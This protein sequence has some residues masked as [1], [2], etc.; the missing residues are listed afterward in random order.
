MAS[1]AYNLLNQRGQWPAGRGSV[2]L[3]TGDL[4]AFPE[5]YF[6]KQDVLVANNLLFP[7]AVNHRIAQDFASFSPPGA[8]LFTTRELG[9]GGGGG[10]DLEAE[11]TPSPCGPNNQHNENLALLEKTQ[12]QRR[13]G[14]EKARAGGLSTREGSASKSAS[15]GFLA[16]DYSGGNSRDSSSGTTKETAGLCLKEEPLT[17][18]VTWRA[19]GDQFFRYTKGLG[20]DAGAAA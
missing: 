3:D 19:S 5:R 4:T 13:A 1:Q 7:E 2:Q 17:A 10:G 12:G 18:G 11:M 8:V 15:R 6:A 16:A 9:L 20:G 14:G